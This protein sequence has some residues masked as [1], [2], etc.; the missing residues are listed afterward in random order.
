MILDTKLVRIQPFQD[1]QFL[2]I[3]LKSPLVETN[4]MSWVYIWNFRTL[5]HLFYKINRKFYNNILVLV[6]QIS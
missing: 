6:E 3:P 1:F 2:T 5:V 4:V